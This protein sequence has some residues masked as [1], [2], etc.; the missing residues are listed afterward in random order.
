MMSPS[1]TIRPVTT[2]VDQELFL[3][4]PARIYANDPYWVPPIRK[5]VAK[6]FQPSHPFRQYG[7]LKQFIAVQNDQ[8]VGRIV[9]AI[10]RRLIEKEQQAVGFFGFFECV[11]NLAIAQAL[12]DTAS[13]WLRQHKMTQVRGPINL[14]T[15]IDCLFLVDGFDSS[16]L[17]MMPYNPSYYPQFLEQLGWSKA[18]DAY[19]YILPLDRPLPAEFER[20]DRIARKAGIHFRPMRLKGEAFRQDCRSLYQ[21]FN[22][23]FA[24]SWSSAPRPEAEFIEEVASL[25]SLA[26][27]E[28]LIFAEDQ[29][30]VVGCFLALPDYNVVLRHLKGKLDWLGMLKFLWYRRQIRQARV[31]AIFVLPEHQRKLVAPALVYQLKQVGEKLR[32]QYHSAELSWVWEDNFLSRNMIEA[33]GATIYK[34]YRIYEQI[35]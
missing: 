8:P 25:K 31:S 22:V 5:D 28:L 27:P 20:S 11:H 15:H 24:D 4:L 12:L 30:Q 2:A 17:L 26:D 21:L 6:Y 34:T 35:L 7:Q 16:P 14:S 10:N 3:D 13:E 33:T 32:R 29:G 18:K 23:A 19:A 1:I 9:A